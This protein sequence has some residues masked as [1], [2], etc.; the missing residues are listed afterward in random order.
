VF[1]IGALT[2]GRAAR[3][4]AITDGPFLVAGAPLVLF[5]APDGRRF[6]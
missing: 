6:G 3:S 5:A 1:A 2:T 4:T